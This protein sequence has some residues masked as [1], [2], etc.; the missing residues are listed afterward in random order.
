MSIFKKG[1]LFIGTSGFYY[2]HWVGRFYPEDLSKSKWLTFFSYKFPSVEIN[3]S[4]YHLPRGKTLLSWYK[5][6]SEGFKFSL[7]ASKYITHTKRLKDVDDELQEFIF[8]ARILKEKLGVI[9]FQLPG[10]LKYDI[11]LLTNFINLLPEGERYA[12]EFRDRSWFREDVYELLNTHNIALCNISSPKIRKLFEV[13]ASF[14]YIRFHGIRRWY[15]YNYTK[16]DLLPWAL[17]IK[18]NLDRGRDVY[19]YFNND[20]S[21]YAVENVC[22][23][24]KLIEEESDD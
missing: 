19:A 5:K 21:G 20:T 23:L 24:K 1:N 6:T 4:F 14:L 3:S 13:T 10:S 7:K 16:E 11:E 9:L 18:Q 17:F 15:D 12:I 2:N 22:L 8:L